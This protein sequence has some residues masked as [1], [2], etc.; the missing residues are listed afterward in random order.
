MA[1]NVLKKMRPPGS[2]DGPQSLSR[3]QLL[4]GAA[5]VAGV[6]ALSATGVAVAQD[7]P[8]QSGPRVSWAP[9]L[10]KWV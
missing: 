6:A 9:A 10:R 5:G 8:L 1:R 4:T 3:R 7:G 2:Q